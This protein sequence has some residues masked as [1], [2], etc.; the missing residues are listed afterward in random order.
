MR[1]PLLPTL[2]VLALATLASG[3]A[4]AQY[5]GPSS[6]QA[7]TVKQLLDHGKDD[8]HVVLRG[9]IV[10]HD[11][12][13]RYTFRDASG[14]MKVEIDAHRLPAGRPFDD[15]AEV[16]LLGE[17]DKDLRSIEVDVDEVRFLR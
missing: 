6:V 14:S 17:V 16:E 8:Q 15:K 10:S 4:A 7:T 2:A 9:R 13:D 11:G 5:T 1:K 12:G 3:Q